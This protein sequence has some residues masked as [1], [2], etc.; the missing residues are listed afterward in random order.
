MSASRCRR[1]ETVLGPKGMRIM[2]ATC[3][4]INGIHPLTFQVVQLSFCNSKIAAAAIIEGLCSSNKF[5]SFVQVAVVQGQAIFM[6][7]L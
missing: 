3:W 4:K 1:V 5:S 2:H 7:L 6:T